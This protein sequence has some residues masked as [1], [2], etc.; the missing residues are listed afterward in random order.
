MET[1][2][3]GTYTTGTSSQGVYRIG[4]DTEKGSLRNLGCAVEMR[5]PSYLAKSGDTLF[6]ADENLEAGHGRLCRFVRRSD[7]SYRIAGRVS[8][9]G[10]NSC[11]VTLSP[12][13]SQVLV[14]NYTSGSVSAFR[15][16]DLTWLF[17]VQG[18]SWSRAHQATWYRNHWLICDLGGDCLWQMG[19]GGSMKN[20]LIRLPA[21]CGPR[22]LV[23]A[24]DL[25]YVGCEHSNELLTVNLETEKVID[26]QST[27]QNPEKE[28][29]VAAVRLLGEELFVSNRGEN[30]V[31]VFSLA[32]PFH[33]TR[34]GT[35]SVGGENPRDILVLPEGIL[36]AC[37]HGVSWLRRQED[38]SFQFAD[39]VEIPSAIA[40]IQE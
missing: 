5:D 33:P 18:R 8:A 14:C 38:G 1:V 31:S 34:T 26:R 19:A 39:K 24:G 15:S 35:Y 6:V 17:T 16:A 11:H 30:T 12:D 20:P 22:H 9:G 29:F 40:L 21:G 23:A 37:K 36:C 27:L 32:D 10:D 28:S 4:L 25:A 13:E 3:V 7:G 2:L